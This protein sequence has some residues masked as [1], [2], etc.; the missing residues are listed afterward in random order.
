MTSDLT[1][2]MG[3]KIF[4]DKCSFL[5]SGN[6]VW[7]AKAASALGR[8]AGKLHKITEKRYPKNERLGF[9]VKKSK[10][11]SFGSITVVLLRHA[12]ENAEQKR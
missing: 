9:Q 6:G 3:E 7:T 11:I 8:K 2:Y 1:V 4:F 12:A 10:I 5:C